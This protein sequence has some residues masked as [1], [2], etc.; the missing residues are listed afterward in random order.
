MLHQQ[1][2]PDDNTPAGRSRSAAF[3]GR[4]RHR[5]DGQRLRCAERRHQGSRVKSIPTRPA[6]GMPEPSWRQ[7]PSTLDHTGLV[8]Q[9]SP[10]RAML[11]LH[12]TFGGGRLWTT[13]AMGCGLS[14]I[15]GR[16]PRRPAQGRWKCATGTPRRCCRTSPACTKKWPN[17]PPNEKMPGSKRHSEA[18]NA[19]A[20]IFRY[21][22]NALVPTLPQVVTEQGSRCAIRLVLLLRN[23]S[24]YRPNRANRAVGGTAWP[25]SIRS[26]T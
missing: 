3:S 11:T 14:S 5:Q 21:R 1:D 20:S 17:V 23:R 7:G 12:R 22:A 2:M 10:W 13:K 16:E 4:L 8:S 26:R 9:P 19:P 18:S 24:R 6:S 25:P 15:G